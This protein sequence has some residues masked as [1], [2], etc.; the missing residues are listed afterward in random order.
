MPP[1]RRPV[2][3]TSAIVPIAAV[4]ALGAREQEDLL[5]VAD[6]GGDR[7]GHAG[8]EDAVVERYEQELHAMNPLLP[9]APCD[10]PL[11]FLK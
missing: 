5:G 8:E 7:H 4:L 1:G 10:E 11:H 6:V 9:G 3:T 2:S